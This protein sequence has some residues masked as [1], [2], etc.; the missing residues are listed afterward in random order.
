M[1]SVHS[2]NYWRHWFGLRRTSVVRWY[3][4]MDVGV[5]NKSCC[6]ISSW[7][8]DHC[9]GRGRGSVAV[10]GDGFCA[11]AL[12]CRLLRSPATP[13]GITTHYLHSFRFRC[14]VHGTLPAAA[15]CRATPTR[16]SRFLPLP[17][18]AICLHLLPHTTRCALCNSAS[19]IC[20]TAHVAYRHYAAP[21][22]RAFT[23]LC[24]A[25][26]ARSAAYAY[27]GACACVP[28]ACTAAHL[29]L[30][31]PLLHSHT[32]PHM[33]AVGIAPALDL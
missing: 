10:C 25:R 13:R 3:S 28:T 6:F 11:L 8:M 30:A 27:P 22:C 5:L 14:R 16:V 17:H 32:F 15:A 33:A 1:T 21:R 7:R 24:A 29:R 2:A 19:R 26:G 20:A 31:Y 12:L 4:G 23:A 18:R 9:L